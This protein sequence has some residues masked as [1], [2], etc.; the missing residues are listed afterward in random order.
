MRNGRRREREERGE[1]E[2]KRRENKLEQQR[3]TADLNQG[4]R[5]WYTEPIYKNLLLYPRSRVSAPLQAWGCVSIAGKLCLI[6][7]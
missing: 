7:V 2:R 4:K 3:P 1:W 6:A 5:R